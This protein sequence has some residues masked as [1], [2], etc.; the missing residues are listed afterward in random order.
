MDATEPQQQPLLT[1]VRLVRSRLPK[2]VVLA[3]GAPRRAE[4]PGCARAEVHASHYGQRASADLNFTVTNQVSPQ[5]VEYL[6]THG[7]RLE[8][9]VARWRGVAAPACPRRGHVFLQLR[10]MDRVAHRDF[11]GG[12]TPEAE[13]A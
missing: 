12:E 6:N 5:G 7:I 4:P 1:P 10:H 13:A 8:A 9:Q 11:L 3:P 2:R